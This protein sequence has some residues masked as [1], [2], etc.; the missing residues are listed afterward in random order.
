MTVSDFSGVFLGIIFWKEASLFSVCVCVG[1]G[2]LF[3]RWRGLHF[4]M[5]GG[6]PW[7]SIGFG[8]DGGEGRGFKKIVRWGA[9]V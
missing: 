2:G 9:P 4:K 3:F 7:G 1:G 8:G 5:A 6:T